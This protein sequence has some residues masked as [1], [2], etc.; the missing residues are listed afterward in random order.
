MAKIS[1]TDLALTTS[2]VGCA[3]VGAS[4]VGFIPCFVLNSG[5][6]G[7]DEIKPPTTQWTL[8]TQD[9]VCG[10]RPVA[11]FTDLPDPSDEGEDVQFTDLSTPAVDITYWHWDFGDGSESY[12]QNPV[13][14]YA[15]AGTYTVTLSVSSPNGMDT[16]T[17]EHTVDAPVPAGSK[18]SG[19]VTA[20]DHG[21][22][23]GIAVSMTVD[24]VAWPGGDAVTDGDGYYEFLNV[25]A[26]NIVLE[27][28]PAN[29]GPGDRYGTEL[30]TT[31]PPADLTVNIN[32]AGI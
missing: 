24:G 15:A 20:D 25:P 16:V 6:Y 23:V 29:P 10:K 3:R 27:V 8:I 4:R 31:V 17:G 22:W 12:E 5:E 2:R 13:H 28:G 30:G 26:G 32:C 9:C 19:I 7:W 11:A 1:G 18:V 14:A 21:I